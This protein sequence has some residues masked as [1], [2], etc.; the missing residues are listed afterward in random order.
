MCVFSA[1][2]ASVRDSVFDYTNMQ[3]SNHCAYSGHVCGQL[4]SEFIC[5]HVS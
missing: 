2:C 5:V 3:R 1:A 4:K